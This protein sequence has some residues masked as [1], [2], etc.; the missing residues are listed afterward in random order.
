MKRVTSLA[1]L[2]KCLSEK[3]ASSL[4]VRLSVPV[5]LEPCVGLCSREKHSVSEDRSV[6]QVC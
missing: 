6:E 3:Q 2:I 1:V 4:L 5:S